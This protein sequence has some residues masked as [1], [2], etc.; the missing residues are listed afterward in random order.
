MLDIMPALSANTYPWGENEFFRDNKNG[1]APV[2]S[3]SCFEL[4]PFIQGRSS[5]SGPLFRPTTYDHHSKTMPKV[6]RIQDYAS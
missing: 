6:P 2:W 3:L 1:K 5:R 4:E